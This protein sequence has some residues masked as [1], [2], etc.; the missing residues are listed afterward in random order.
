MNV[1]TVAC[2][3]ALASTVAACG[4]PHHGHLHDHRYSV[5]REGSTDTVM[6]AAREGARAAY[7]TQYNPGD[8]GLSKIKNLPPI[9]LPPPPPGLPRRR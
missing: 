7:K 6:R 8:Y 9:S 1:V 3:L 2:S 5:S 4:A